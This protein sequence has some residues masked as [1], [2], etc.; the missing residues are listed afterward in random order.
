[1]TRLQRRI[2]GTVAA[3]TAV[4]FTALGRSPRPRRNRP[5]RNRP[6]A[7]PPAAQRPAASRCSST[8]CSPPP[9]EE[10]WDG[11]IH[12]AHPGRRRDRRDRVQVRRRPRHRRRDGARPA[13][14][15]RQRGPRPHRRRRLR[16]RGG[17]ARRRR[18][19]PRHRVRLRLGWR[20]GGA[21]LQRVRQLAAGPGLPR[22]HA[23]R[24]ADRDGHDRRRRGDADPRGQPHRQRLRRLGVGETNPDATVKV[25]FIN[26]FFDPATAGAGRRG[27]DRP[28]RRRAV[29]RAGRRDRGRRRERPAGDRDDGRPARPGPRQRGDVAGLEHA[30]DDRGTRRAGVG[31]AATRRRTW[32]ST[33]SWSTAAARSP[34]STPTSSSRCPT[35]WWP[36]S[37]R[38]RPRSSTARSTTP[39]DEDEPAGSIARSRSGRGATRRRAATAADP[40]ARWSSAAGIT[41][42]FG[43]LVANDA[44][45]LSV[46]AGEVHALLGENGAGKSTL[47]TIL[48]GL[49]QPDAGEILI[50]GRR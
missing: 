22:R 17:R 16:R 7:N 23:R 21:Q 2:I 42:R 20:R 5:R 35:I 25:S 24:R 27:A 3:A 13:R 46:D 15:H 28:G 29:R 40:V 31:A 26:S 41:K 8:A 33:R 44:I 32:P 19:L 49:S 34:R 9:L 12:A 36:R 4:A 6:A 48:Y 39:V 47:T 38:G 43:A 45:D 1:M 30:A 14:H 10:P 18:R 11:A 37:R 50:D